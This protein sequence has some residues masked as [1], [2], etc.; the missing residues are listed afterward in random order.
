MSKTVGRFGGW[1]DSAEAWIRDQAETGDWSRKTILDA[2]TKELLGDI[3]GHDVLDLGCG[4]GRFCRVMSSLGAMCT[5]I[6][7]VQKFIRAAQEQDAGGRYVIGNAEQL[8]FAD[9]SFDIVLS[10]LTFIDIPNLAEA[11]REAARVLRPSGRVVVINISNFCC[12]E[13]PWIRDESGNKLHRPVADYME[14]RAIVYEWRDIR[15]ENYHRPLSTLFG[16]LL[17]EGL[18][19]EQFHEPLPP[20]TDPG[21]ETFASAPNFQTMVLRKA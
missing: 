15:I 4:E 20:K 10:Y 12:T 14:E 16:W 13:Q 3:S 6:D 7:P 9:A 21:Y 5:G 8:P 11:I 1:E 2:H 18:V 19:L 17:G